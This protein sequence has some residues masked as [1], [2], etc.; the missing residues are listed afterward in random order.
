MPFFENYAIEDSEDKSEHIVQDILE[1]TGVALVP[2]AAFGHPN[3]ARMSM[4][5]EVAP[6]EEAMER[7]VAFMAVKSS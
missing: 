5:L 1:Q 2:G 6:F 7:L 4:T 3:S